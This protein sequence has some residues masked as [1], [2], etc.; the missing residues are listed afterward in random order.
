MATHHKQAQGYNP[1]SL[2][3][4]SQLMTRPRRFKDVVPVGA[5]PPADRA[6]NQ[7]ESH[8]PEAKCKAHATRTPFRCLV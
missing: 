7:P 6:L 8:C 1:G 3:N 2:R 5:K 4:P